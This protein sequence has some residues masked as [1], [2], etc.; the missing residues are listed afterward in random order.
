MRTKNTGKIILGLSA[1]LASSFT[2]AGFTLPALPP[3]TEFRLAFV[4]VGTTTATSTDIADYNAFVQADVVLH[5]GDDLNALG[6]TWNAIGST[7]TVDA[8]DNTGTN[9][10]VAPGV[11]IYLL[12]GTLLAANNA[13][14]WDGSVSSPLSVDLLMNPFPVREFIWTGSTIY[15]TAATYVIR[16]S[17]VNRQLGASIVGFGLS[18]SNTEPWIEQ[19]TWVDGSTSGMGLYG[20]SSILVTPRAPVPETGA[21]FLLLGVA[22]AALGVFKRRVHRQVD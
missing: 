19:R 14:L 18:R 11:P 15:G 12:N 8:R 13:D 6:A 3:G 7:A 2:A 20:L 17:E 9:P 16:G 22:C 21:T 4:T 10:E 5:G 1:A